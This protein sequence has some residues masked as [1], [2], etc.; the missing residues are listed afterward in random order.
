MQ[1]A[2][3]YPPGRHLGFKIPSFIVFQSAA[4]SA[5]PALGNFHL[6][7]QDSWQPM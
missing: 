3:Q 4:A 1:R 7:G 5:E 6:Q 2:I